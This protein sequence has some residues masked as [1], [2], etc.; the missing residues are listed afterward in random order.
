MKHLILGISIVLTLA[1]PCISSDLLSPSTDLR[2][3]PE[4]SIDLINPRGFGDV[5]LDGTIDL[6]T[7]EGYSSGQLNHKGNIDLITPK[8]L[9]HG[10]VDSHG[11]ITIWGPGGKVYYGDM[12]K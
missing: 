2:G 5:K 6:W 10:D 4:G 1:Y 11:N 8:G 9:G 12:K 3:S 7:K